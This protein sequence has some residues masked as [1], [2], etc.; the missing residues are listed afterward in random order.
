MARR[1]LT[2]AQMRSQFVVIDGVGRKDS[3]QVSLAED[4]DVIEAFPADR[5]RSVSPHARSARATSGRSVIAYTHGCKALRDGVAV[6]PVAISDHVVRCLIPREGIG[7]LTGDP[8]CSR[9]VGD[10]QRIIRRRRSCR[11]MTRTKSNRKPTVGTIRKSIAPTPASWLW[12]KV[13]QVC[14]PP[15]PAPRHVL[16]DRRLGELEAELEKFAMYARRTPQPVGQAH[17]PDQPTDLHRNFRP[18]APRARLPAPI[19][20]KARPM[21]PDDGLRWTIVTAFNT[22]GNRR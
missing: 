12:R 10:A 11:R 18:P 9:M 5:G 7:D 14:R 4:D 1:I 3:P 2:Q 8:L 19:Q 21:P 15:S 6:A 17:L 20:S 16:G 22:D 13:F